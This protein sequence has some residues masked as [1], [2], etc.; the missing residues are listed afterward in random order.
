MTQKHKK[1]LPLPVYTILTLAIVGLLASACALLGGSSSSTT[2]ATSTPSARP[3]NAHPVAGQPVATGKL[4]PGN[5]LPG[6]EVKQL[7]FDLVYNDAAMERDVTAVYTPASATYHQ[8]LT[9]DQ[10]VQRY[11]P[12]SA[13]QQMVENWLTQNGYTIVTVDPMHSSIK[14]QATV[15]TIE[16]TLNIKLQAFSLAGHEF[17]MQQGVPVLPASIAA[18]VPE[19]LGLDNF[20]LPEFR[21][22]FGLTLHSTAFAGNCSNYGAKHTLTREKLAAA[23]QLDQ[24]YQKGFQ[25]QGMTI[26]VAE[27]G[28]TYDPRAIANYDTCAGVAPVSIQNVDVVGHLSPGPGEGEAALDL[29]LI[30]GL[31]PKAQIL[32]YQ[33]EQGNVSFAQELVDV[34]NRV[35]ADHKVQV[36]SVSYGTG[37][38]SFS[39]SEQAAVNRSLR[40]LAAMGV[41]VFISSGDCGAFTLRV[42]NIAEVSFPAS[43]P[44]AIAVGGTHLQVS[45]S[46][47]RT[48]EDAW[49]GDDGAPL[50][51]NEWGSGGGVSQNQAFKRPSWQV[52]P[53]TTISYDGSSSA[54]PTLN[55]A[56]IP[57]SAPNGLRQVPDLAA[58]AYPNIAIYYRGAWLA[59]GGTSAAAPIVAAGM[60]LVDQSLKQQGKTLFGSV[61][62]IY[63]IA[64]HPGSFHPY[65]DITRGDNL[66]YHATR[67]WDYTTGWGSP[68]FNDILQV[69]LTR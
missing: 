46:N 6:N 22:P 3:S 66:F 38:D 16:R 56:L 25:G 27:F 18:L 20:A 36:L 17:F 61:P 1:S 50:C 68:N 30:S 9:P 67:G 11:G 34:F 32:D 41:S 13:Q 29:E 42:H 54:P 10:I 37:E 14:V 59:A 57:V 26:G 15:A 58:A 5:P 49:G 21:P 7:V 33:A 52:G 35:A 28:D 23:Y 69:E 31:A 47:V 44:Y 62:E 55:P 12:S 45:D 64:N 39:A 65:N 48:S 4:P 2:S 19:V 43:A 51:H 63:T 53:G 60:L 40:N 24:F 8:F